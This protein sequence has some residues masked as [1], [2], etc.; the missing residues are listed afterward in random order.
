M[1]DTM[2]ILHV[3]TLLFVQK[4]MSVEEQEGLKTRVDRKSIFR[5]LNRLEESGH[6][7]VIRSNIEVTEDSVKQV[8]VN[9]TLS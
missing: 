5:I 3:V 9:I 6:I 7:K 2:E 1:S 8:S 4:I